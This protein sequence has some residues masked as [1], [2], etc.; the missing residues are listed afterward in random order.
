MLIARIQFSSW[1]RN[2]KNWRW[3]HLKI[4]SHKKEF[5]IL[6]DF[7]ISM[8][9]HEFT[10]NKRYNSFGGYF[11]KLSKQKAF[12]FIGSKIFVLTGSRHISPRSRFSNAEF[13]D[14][15]TFRSRLIHNLYKYKKREPQC[16]LSFFWPENEKYIISL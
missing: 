13:G 2:L 5:L 1:P 9:I 3:K 6:T 15:R 10:S 12:S 14:K 4:N 11:N 16:R 7:R 8:N